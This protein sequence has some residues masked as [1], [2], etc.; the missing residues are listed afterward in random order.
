MYRLQKGHCSSLLQ[1]MREAASKVIL[2]TTFN[3]SLSLR[4]FSPFAKVQSSSSVLSASSFTI[5]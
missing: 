2:D 5:D 3:T 1:M 4:L